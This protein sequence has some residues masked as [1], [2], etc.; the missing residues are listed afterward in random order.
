MARRAAETSVPLKESS[1][2]YSASDELESEITNCHLS[3]KTVLVGSSEIWAAAVV[4]EK[5]V[6]ARPGGWQRVDINQRQL[7]YCG[8]K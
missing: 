2:S 8:G 4:R 6:I 7:L 3:E 5:N 1:L